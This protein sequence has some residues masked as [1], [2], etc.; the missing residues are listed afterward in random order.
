MSTGL[1]YNRYL[2]STSIQPRHSDAFHTHRAAMLIASPTMQYSQRDA[3]PTLPQ[4]A[5]PEDTPMCRSVMLLMSA[6]K[7]KACF[8]RAVPA[9]RLK[10]GP[11]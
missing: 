4:K 3:D 11:V 1:E 2:D 8:R 10:R 9:V 6:V 7:L 5:T